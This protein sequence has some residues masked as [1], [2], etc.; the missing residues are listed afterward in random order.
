MPVQLTA[1]RPARTPVALLLM[2]ALLIAGCARRPVEALITVDLTERHQQIVGWEA[3]ASAGEDADLSRFLKYR[4]VV[5]DQL[6]SDLGVTR[7]RLE[8]RA[9][10]ENDQ[11]YFAMQAARTI[12]YPT[13]RSK[14]YATVNDN[15]DPHLINWAG[16]FFSELDRKVELVVNPI[17]ELVARAGERPFVNLCY[18]AFT[19]QVRH[20]G[21]YVH[22]DPKEYG[23]YIEAIW[24]HMRRKFGWVPD[25]LEIILEPDNTREWNGVLIGHAIVEVA[26]RLKA[27]GFEVP[28]FVA[29]STTNMAKA[30]GYFYDMIA[31]PGV[32]GLLSE[33][34]YHRYGGVSGRALRTIARSAKRHR[35]DTAM[36]EF[37]GADAK[38]L[39]Q[40]LQSGGNVAWSQ[41]V[42]AG[43]RPDRG[44]A[45]LLVDGSVPAHMAVQPAAQTRMLRHYFRYIRPGATRIGAASNDDRVNPVAF[46]NP[47]G[48]VVVVIKC[49]EAGAVSVSGLPA[50]NYE[51]TYSTG[52]ISNAT[53]PAVTIAHNG[54]VRAEMP[55]AGVMTVAGTK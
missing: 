35:V 25:S 11:D 40:D 17:R 22:G 14:R 15:D 32:S 50:S 2:L 47:A 44:G 43:Q 41:Y 30:V 7:L 29:P 6:V 23:E 46:E 21:P 49:D 34:S 3:T 27:A 36:L 51:L 28:R 9:G 53:L 16:F 37:I 13:W 26:R 18:V 24:T 39:H 4:D 5:F 48:G 55:A 42:I 8:V 1:H 45:Y 20:G 10:G 12:D 52:T 54:L 38:V 33:L 19:G 31:V